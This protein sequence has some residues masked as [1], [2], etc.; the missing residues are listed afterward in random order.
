MWLSLTAFF[1]VCVFLVDTLTNR[2]LEL[3]FQLRT[4]GEWEKEW[5]QERYSRCRDSITRHLRWACEKDIYKLKRSEARDIFALK[6]SE[7]IQP[8]EETEDEEE[9]F[10][11]N[12]VNA[13]KDTESQ[14]EI[15][16]TEEYDKYPW[17][18]QKL[19]M[20]LI[21]TRRGLSKR[22]GVITQ[23][24]C[25]PKDAP[26]RNTPSIVRKTIEKYHTNDTSTFTTIKDT[27]IMK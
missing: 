16:E 24:C 20:G 8:N 12:N 14:P 5:H 13:F 9:K 2:E 22:S 27:S 3:K 6:R 7:N 15:L 23:E 11:I 25:S 1:A 19:A 26:G 18:N 21:R 4:P 10:T 17:L